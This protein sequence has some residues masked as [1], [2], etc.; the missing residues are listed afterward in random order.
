[1]PDRVVGGVLVL[2]ST[3]DDVSPR[4]AAGSF[5]RA[6]VDTEALRAAHG[7]HPVV[8]DAA[9]RCPSAEPCEWSAEMVDACRP[10]LATVV[11]ALRPTRILVLGEAAAMAVLGPGVP[12]LAQVHRG[13]A[14]T[15]EGVPVFL[16]EAP[17]DVQA[18][19]FL[20]AEW[21][22]NARWALG[23]NPPPPPWRGTA[24]VIETREDALHAAWR[25][26]RAAWVAWDVETFGRAFD[27]GFEVLSVAVCAEGEDSAFVWD[28]AA[29]ARPELLA[30]LLA[31]L[32]DPDLEKTAMNGKFDGIAARCAWGIEVA[33]SGRD[34]GLERALLEPGVMTRLE[35]QQ[36]LVGM[37]GG[38][39]EMAAA[40][41]AAEGAVVRMAEAAA[42]GQASLFAG[43][44]LPAG[45]NLA[46]VRANPAAYAYAYCDRTL[47]SRYNA[48]DAVSTARLERRHQARLSAPGNEPLRYVWD[49]LVRHALPTIEQIEAWGV[50]VNA[51]A[52]RALGAYLALEQARVRRR[53]EVHG[54]TEPGSPDKVA[55]LLFG[56]LKLTPTHKTPGG[57]PST[58]EEA[59]EG[60]KN[61]HPVVGDLLEWRGLDK[62]RGTYCEGLAR[63]VT[64]DGLVHVDYDIAGARSGRMSA[65][66]G[67][68]GLPRPETD[69]GKMVRN[70]IVASPGCE[71]VEIDVSQAEIRALGGLSDDPVMVETFRAGVDYHQ[72]TAEGV[73]RR[74][75]NIE[76]S[77]VKSVHRAQAK[78]INLAMIYGRGDAALAEE[79][80]VKSGIPCTKEGAGLI[81]EAVLGEIKVASAWMAEQLAFATRYGYART[82][83]RGRPARRR[84]LPALG[85][86]D[87]R[88]HRGVRGNAERAASNTPV[89]GTNADV[90]LDGL[91]VIVREVKRR[92][93]RARLG[94]TVHDSAL[95]DV[96]RDD[97]D[98]LLA[99]AAEVFGALSYGR[100]PVVVDAKRGQSYGA[101]KKTTLGNAQP[102]GVS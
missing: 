71:L 89:Q 47:L 101:L 94:L 26:G 7:S 42:D 49:E 65:R 98:A 48:L 34:V 46:H 4:T 82:W 72:R 84:P 62:L 3:S 5:V 51:E 24:E 76:P 53:L 95:F 32:Q 78:I 29:L 13:W 97:V 63:Q 35:V 56:K 44:R 93:L 16:L 54:L 11:R 41:K 83:L 19:R 85:L 27:R 33:G 86:P 91:V 88:E 20:R 14:H 61:A 43:A 58:S 50:R 79:I 9:L 15:A 77:A 57:Q 39:A 87:T 17:G 40:V 21:E 6:A 8:Y 36:W 102:H 81:R 74:V 28:R 55:E 80:T 100:I 99:L 38:K 92:G 23:A 2:G 1:M 30:P 90:V 12:P 22:A 70:C 31:L 64:D 37:G 75:W 59:I 69:E 73:S 60:L 66:G 68:H 96:H 45:V 25:L 52:V 18:N 10:Y 67:M